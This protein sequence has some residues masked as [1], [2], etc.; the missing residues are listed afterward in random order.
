MDP[1]KF[2]AIAHRS[3]RFCSPISVTTLNAVLDALDLR[4]GTRVVDFGCGNGEML[5]HVMSRFGAEGAGV[6]RS[7][8]ML[9]MARERADAREL[10]VDWHEGDAATFAGTGFDLAIAVGVDRLFPDQPPG[11]EGQLRGLSGRLR[12]GGYILFGE[13]YW[14]APPEPWYLEALG[15]QS[16]DYTDHTGNV[17]AGEAVG[18]IPYHARTSSEVEWDEYEWRY[19]RSIEQYLVEHPEDPDA[20]AM[21]TRIKN[22]RHLYLTGG[23]QFLGFGMYL[24]RKP[25]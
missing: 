11:V 6:E 10:A 5:L 19:S 22:W 16:S 4:P 25:L 23:R 14:K 8:A 17:T 3:H 21:R 15:A 1:R 20:E 13:G 12:P 18:L 9:T 7:G 24:F 2:S